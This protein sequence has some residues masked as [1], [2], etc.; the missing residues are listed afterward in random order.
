MDKKNRR[1]EIQSKVR[2]PDMEDIQKAASNFNEVTD[3]QNRDFVARNAKHFIST[4]DSD[5]FE[6]HLSEMKKEME[7]L[8]MAVASEDKAKIDPA[9]TDS[10]DVT[11]SSETIS[12]PLVIDGLQAATLTLGAADTGEVSEDSV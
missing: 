1:F 5:K 3:E 4:N 2:V 11:I 12:E 6:K 10:T 9:N 8:A 7:Q